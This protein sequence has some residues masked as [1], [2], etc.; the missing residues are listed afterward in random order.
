MKLKPLA[1]GIALGIVWGGALFVTTWLS[2]YTGYGKLFLEVLAQ[3]IYP[4]YTISPIGS[5]LGLIYGF[6]DGLIS[7]ALIGLIYNKITKI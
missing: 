6:V 1:L 3:S 7:A 2:Y 5:F 4:G